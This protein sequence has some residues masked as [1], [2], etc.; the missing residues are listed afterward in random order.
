MTNK[1]LIVDDE[2]NNLD[3]LNNCLCNA[4]FKVLVAE[5]G[6]TA[7]KRAHFI[8]PDLIL[9]DVKMPEMDGYEVCK[10]LKAD[11]K[12]RSIPIIFISALSE[13]FDKIK[14]FTVGGVDYVTKPFH[15]EEVLARVKTHLRLQ[16][17]QKQLQIQAE[18]LQQANEQLV[19]LNQEKN[20]FLAVAVH[21]LKNPLSAILSLVELVEDS[22]EGNKTNIIRCVHWIK[23]SVKHMFDIVTNLLDVNAIDSGK[24]QLKLTQT[25]IL[26]VLSYIVCEYNQKASCKEITLDFTPANRKYIAYVDIN[27][28]RQILD[29]LLSNAVKYSSFGKKVSIRIF[30]TQNATICC[31]IQ[32]E[33]PGLSHEEQA[34]L[35]LKFRRLSPIPTNHENSTGLGLFIV[36]KLVTAMG[37][38][39]WCESE[40]GKGSKF[41]VEFIS[42]QPQI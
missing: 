28:V 32:D 14:A 7:L 17:Q 23:D 21:D 6:E 2:P 5:D 24:L 18:K 26:P 1:I 41:V 29:N 16:A 37:G 22:F 3:V 8:K 27:R 20:E 39:V 12:T 33:G 40:L 13:T 10:R 4:G 42:T 19:Q 25:D 9:L 15:K 36:K 11:E 31:E 38:K 34:K 30:T 35:F